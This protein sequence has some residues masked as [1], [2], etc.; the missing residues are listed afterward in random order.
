MNIELNKYEAAALKSCCE[1]KMKFFSH[2][3]H[4]IRSSALWKKEDCRTFL[5]NS[6]D[7]FEDRYDFWLGIYFKL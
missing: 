5:K 4:K 1:Q 3:F 6:M 7:G 2:E